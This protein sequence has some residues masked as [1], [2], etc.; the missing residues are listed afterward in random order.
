MNYEPIKVELDDEMTSVTVINERGEE[1]TL[2]S[3]RMPHSDFYAAMSAL[4]SVFCRHME[5]PDS[6]SERV[7]IRGIRTKETKNASG[8][9]ISASLQCPAT[10]SKMDVRSPMLERTASFYWTMKDE[11]GKPVHLPEKELGKLTGAEVAMCDLALAEAGLYA[12][13]GKAR[14]TADLFS[15]PDESKEEK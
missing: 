4:A 14:K 10:F 8:F 9:V 13:E 3:N 12:K 11:D 2:I 6:L 5:I 1:E 15:D 7:R